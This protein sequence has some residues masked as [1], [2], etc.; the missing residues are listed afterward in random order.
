MPIQLLPDRQHQFLGDGLQNRIGILRRHGVELTDALLSVEILDGAQ[1]EVQLVDNAV[2]LQI[3]KPGIDLIGRIDAESVGNTLTP[4]ELLQ[5]LVDIVRVPNLHLFRE[6]WI[7]QYVDYA[8]FIRNSPPVTLF[9][10]LEQFLFSQSFYNLHKPI[11]RVRTGP[12]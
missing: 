10:F 12:I 1:V 7:G 4:V 6:G 2:D 8:C 5:P 9:L 3:G 11:I